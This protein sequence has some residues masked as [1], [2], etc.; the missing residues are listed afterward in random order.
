MAED[1]LIILPTCFGRDER[2]LAIIR[3]YT[4]ITRVAKSKTADQFLLRTFTSF[5]GALVEYTPWVT[6]TSPLLCSIILSE[7]T[8]YYARANLEDAGFVAA[9]ATLAGC[10]LDGFN[11]GL[12][13]NGTIELKAYTALLQTGLCL[14]EQDKCAGQGYWTQFGYGATNAL[15]QELDVAAMVDGVL[16]IVGKQ[17][18]NKFEC[19]KEGGLI[20]L[21][22]T[23]N[24]Y[25][26][27]VHI[28]SKC[29]LGIDMT[30][31]EWKA[32]YDKITT[33]I[34]KNWTDPYLHGQA[35]VFV[36]S[37]AVPITKLSKVSKL[38]ILNKLKLKPSFNNKVDDLNKIINATEEGKDIGKV[39]DDLA[40]G[41]DVPT[42]LANKLAQQ[43]AAK[44]KS[45][46]GNKS[47]SYADNAGAKFSGSAAE[48]KIFNDL[49]AAIGNKRVV[50]TI[51]DAQGRLLIRTD[52]TAITETKVISFEITANGEYKLI[53][54]KA[55]YNK[56][57]QSGYPKLSENKLAPDFS[58]NVN[59]CLHPDVLGKK[60]EINITGQMNSN[61]SKIG[62]VELANQT[63]GIAGKNTPVGY[64]WHHMD[65][66]NPSTGKC[67]MQ[68]VRTTEHQK[69]IP[70][71]GG[72]K[73][74]ENFS[75]Q[76]YLR[77]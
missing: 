49:E 73:Q 44:L 3:D 36:A 71:T 22:V 11:R 77:N 66:F 35:A 56:G 39:M 72:V 60:I 28:A 26:E 57:G 51:E 43:G 6:V 37:F 19:V 69:C 70:H 59:N 50:E 8:E 45:W 18:K 47:M 25:E 41:A 38:K 16:F 29:L 67:T 23:A 62:D 42:G 76:S 40:R 68:L 32:M 55:V 14:T 4:S 75:G 34:G 46:L 54:Y 31:A 21:V 30:V 12:A 48:T 10:A 1:E 53:E 24:S 63:A 65:D 61:G 27:A 7:A 52:A 9:G 20:Y 58:D 13:T 2:Q 15:L 17:L 5:A 64:T 33:Y 74:W